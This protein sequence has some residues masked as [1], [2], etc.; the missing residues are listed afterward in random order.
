MKG[1]VSF[2]IGDWKVR[3]GELRMLGGQGQGRIRGCLC[4]VEL[5]EDV[6]DDQGSQE[7]IK[8]LAKAFFESLIEGS[9]VDVGAMKVIGHVNGEGSQIVRQYM[10]LLKFAR[11]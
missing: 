9:G 6:G 10:D 1:G 5:P 8:E 2:G 4:E 3:I 11:N 7:G